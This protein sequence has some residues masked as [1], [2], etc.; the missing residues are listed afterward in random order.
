MFTVLEPPPTRTRFGTA[1]GRILAVAVGL[2]LGA[3]LASVAAAPGMPDLPGDAEV[4]ALAATIDPEHPY[5]PAWG[6]DYLQSRPPEDMPYGRMPGWL[7]FLLGDTTVESHT[8]TAWIDPVTPGL[9]DA[10]DP[11]L[12]ADGWR[13]HR[14]L[15]GVL[16]AHRGTVRLA[17][18]TDGDRA[19]LAVYRVAGPWH[20]WAVLGG[21]LLG[22]VA[23]FLVARW[24]QRR[25][26]GLMVTLGAV[27]VLPSFMWAVG[28]VVYELERYGSLDTPLWRDAR[29]IPFGAV[30]NLAMLLLAIGLWRW[31]AR[32]GSGPRYRRY[33]WT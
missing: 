25:P 31:P 9:V 7:R 1:L 8:G 29:H 26:V 27:G 10:A 12:R 2:T 14:P 19:E 15:P 11:R 21:A 30:L 6:D 13:T 18:L 32:D 33:G 22:A 3:L 28:M 23:A 4:E 17:Y 5:E 24:A 20:V 16:E